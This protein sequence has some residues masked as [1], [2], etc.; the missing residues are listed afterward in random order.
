[1]KETAHLVSAVRFTRLPSRSRR[2]RQNPKSSSGVSAGCPA[3]CML[4]H[5]AWTILDRAPTQIHSP[6]AT[7]D[8]T[9]RN[10]NDANS[11]RV[12]LT[13]MSHRYV[14]R[15]Q[16]SSITC[17]P[18]TTSRSLTGRDAPDGRGTGGANRG[19]EVPGFAPGEPVGHPRDRRCVRKKTPIPTVAPESSRISALCALTKG[20][21]IHISFLRPFL[22]RFVRSRRTSQPPEGHVGLSGDVGDT[23]ASTAD[24]REYV[25]DRS[26]CTSHGPQ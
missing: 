1:M 20:Y 23:D 15:L 24:S 16:N 14:D 7:R 4:S 21:V 2:K 10:V 18:F 17:G 8:V 5:Q 11:E 3:F 12:Y 22:R 13:P 19:L 26:G 6:R 9:Q 25:T